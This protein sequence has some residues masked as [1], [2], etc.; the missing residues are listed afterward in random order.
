MS[1]SVESLALSRIVSFALKGSVGA[2]QPLMGA[3][4]GPGSVVEDVHDLGE[5][6][7]VDDTTVVVGPPIVELVV[8][9]LVDVVVAIDVDVEEDVVV[10][11]TP[12]ATQHG[13]VG[14]AV[15]VGAGEITNPGTKTGGMVR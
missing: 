8:D 5:V 1:L 11:L 9:E 12:Q 4:H 6:D 2:R 13:S 3:P 14:S 10:V 7:E 15:T